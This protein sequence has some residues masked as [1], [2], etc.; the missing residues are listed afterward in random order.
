[1]DEK[2]LQA[3]EEAFA[4]PLFL[5]RLSEEGAPG[6]R[7]DAQAWG[8]LLEP[9]LPTKERVRCADVVE[10]CRVLLEQ[11]AQAP[12]E[13]WL[14]YISRVAVSLAFPEEIDHTPAQR[15]AALTFLQAL[16]VLLDRERQVLPFDSSRDFA[17]CT[18]EELR[19]SDRREEYRTFLNAWRGDCV[20]E[21][22]RLSAET[23][24]FSTLEHIAGVHH[25]AMTMARE[26]RAAGGEVDLAMVSAS[27]ACHDI[28]KFGCRTGE[29]V[30]YLHYYYTDQWCTRRNLPDVGHIAA[31]HSTWDLEL[32]NLSAENLLLIYADFR[33]KQE[34]DDSGRERTHIYTLEQSYDVI[35]SKLD[36]VDDAKR[37]RYAFVYAKLCDFQEYLQDLGVDVTLEGHPTAPVR[38]PDAALLSHE[39]TVRAFRLLAVEHNL[40]LMHRFSHER[41]FANVLE[42]ARSE[43][44]WSRVRAYVSIL[45]E[46]FTYLTAAQ[47]AQSLSFLY[48]LL[49][50]R[51]GDI[52]RQAAALI[53]RI[54]AC[55]NAGYQKELPKTAAPSSAQQTQFALWARYLDL[56]IYPD[57]KLTDPQKSHIH[58]TMKI[59]VQTVLTDCSPADAPR[60]ME[61]IRRYY[62]TPCLTDRE[63]ALALTDTL[64]YLPPEL[65]GED[66]E[67]LTEFAAVQLDRNDLVLQAAAMR[68]FHRVVQALPPEHP[69]AVRAGALARELD[70]SGSPALLYL[71]ACI[72]RSLG[73]SG[74]AQMEQLS[75][76]EVVSD[77]FVDNL[78]NATHWVLKAVNIELLTEQV[79]RGE[80]ENL[81][82]IAAHFGNLLKVS[83]AIVVR[84]NA[85]GSLLQIAD[86]LSFDQRNEVAVE[87]AKGLEVGQY[88]YSKYIPQCLGEFILHL[89]PTELD[90]ML[91]RLAHLMGNSSDTTVSAALTTVGVSLEHY[92][93]YGERFGETPEVLNA[94]RERMAG[95]LLKGLSSYRETVR[96]EAMWVIG[97]ELFG[98]QTLTFWE[99][100]E[101]FTLMAD[102]MLFLFIEHREGELTYF[103]RAAALSHIYRFIVEHQILEGPF[104][105]EERLPVAFFPGTF[106]P[107]TLSHKGIVREIRDLGFEVYLAVDEF[108][109]SKKAQPSLIRRQIVSMSVAD[110][111]HVRLFPL[112][113][114]VN[115]ANP[116][117]LLRL[118]ALFPG[119]E[120]Y[121]AVGSDVVEGASSYK[122]PPEHGS[123]HSLNH[124]VFRRASSIH[125][126]S[127]GDEVDLGCITGK[128]LQ[129]RLP[130][131]LEDISST[132]IR[133]N[134]DMNRDISNLIDPVV[135]E[136]I[137]QN[138]LY[139]REPQ[140]KPLMEGNPL[141]FRKV[142]RPT[143]DLLRRLGAAVGLSGRRV[144]AISRE[145]LGFATILRTT[146]DNPQTLGFA[147]G[148][149]I[150]ST[151]LRSALGSLRLAD[152]VRS[153]TAGRILLLSGMYAA[154]EAGDWDV[155]QLL[156]TE[157][158]SDSMA[159]DCTYAL[160]C[161]A[162]GELTEEAEDALWRQGF[163]RIPD[164]EDEKPLL[165]VDM[166]SPVAVMQNIETTIKPPFSTAPAVLSAIRKAYRRFQEALCTLY[167]GTLILSLNTTVIHHRLV[168][169]IT[170]RNGVPPMPTHPRTL[171]PEMCVPFGK[172]L[173][174]HAVPNTVT[175]TIHTDKVYSPDLHEKTIE[176]FPY[177]APLESQV[178]TVRSF[179]RPVILVDDMMHTGDRIRVL[180]PMARE[181]GVH[182]SQ[183]LVGLLSGRGRDLI[184]ERQLPVDA[185]YFVPDLRA[186]YVESSFYPFIGGDTVRRDQWSV[187]GLLPSINMILPYTC[188]RFLRVCGREPAFRFSRTCLENSRDILLALEAEY[189]SQ[190]GR[191]LTL[192][193]LSEAV[194]L[195]LCPDKG[196][197]MSYDPNL[198]ASV[199]LEN[200]LAALMRMRNLFLEEL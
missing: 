142:E 66:W 185:I 57:H 107:F 94:R 39:E 198:A 105:F 99:K 176:A 73:E 95:M 161:P 77:I 136:F 38:R 34:K 18:R 184:D 147:T 76:R 96:Q 37:R 169:R 101:L 190:F 137:Y 135:E 160:Y 155:K 86:R 28:G 186:W 33:V 171:G 194:I 85:G 79:L 64:C 128:V 27:A 148:R 130:T 9:L 42:A 20:Y 104:R 197:C 157:V 149:L 112:D 167:P 58:Y 100:T 102:K 68:F 17:F 97:R 15:G 1:M 170:E 189:R 75:R 126:D 52:R 122:K 123:V 129:L 90:E 118:R 59:T 182:I 50:D 168:E 151:E 41:L 32:E 159:Q 125:G 35:L 191:N 46:Y 164:M 179:E 127:R 196:S 93:V 80:R 63:A 51:E 62:D 24:P 65:C 54:I 193:R 22:M 31:N 21:T 7:P 19:S 177:Y 200:D 67:R 72:L 152:Y 88:E 114:P 158:L 188:P 113:I 165:L 138:S 106:D 173:R 162:D 174:G 40:H 139:L 53:G 13:G 11:E 36:N 108:S 4:E 141:R 56:M 70:C 119:R 175:K 69:A 192:S 131:H 115:I 14:F 47:K 144:E 45:E 48:E 145:Y 111:F 134:V 25:V 82:H 121:L 124:I 16:R 146:G 132:R 120:L 71:Q 74:E 153:R 29:R 30:P 78:K 5:E 60:F 166:R 172:L 44:A 55:F 61:G 12:R 83:D 150:S 116:Q 91:D 89:R 110:E 92:G 178:R 84:Y 180:E 163:L 133:E 10:Q 117:D 143:P 2:L 81:L 199:Y 181:A 140:Y 26:L 49:M 195:P 3:L 109:W 87:M 156:L 98:S 103:Y 23:T 6:P 154:R 8:R 187:P 43:K 183:V